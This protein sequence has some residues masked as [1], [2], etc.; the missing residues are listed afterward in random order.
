M[1]F[2][3]YW[4]Y[5][6]FLSGRIFN[7]DDTRPTPSVR[8]SDGVDYVPTDSKFLSGQ[9]FSAIA[10]AGPITGPI[11]AGIMFG[12]APA[13]IWIILGSILIGGVHDMGAIIASVRHNARSITE[14]VRRNVS[15]RAWLLFLMFTWLSLVYVIVAFT[16]ITSGSFVGTITLDNGQQVG[17][18]GIATSSLLY[19]ALPVFMG[20]LLKKTR[21]SLTWATVIFL[22]LVGCLSGWAPPFRCNLMPC[23]DPGYGCQKVWNG[24]LLLYCF[25]VSLLPMWMLLQPRGIWEDTSCMPPCWLL[26]LA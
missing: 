11:V 17:G 25:V 4:V 6:T 15:R 16:D 20:I 10:G 7:I 19:L 21:L 8:F 9:H 2:V 13:L 5:G 3:A 22:P 18:G 12:W 23:W 14:V 24:F 26:P 1:F